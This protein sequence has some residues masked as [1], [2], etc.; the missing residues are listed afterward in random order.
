M[1]NDVIVY[2]NEN[3]I[4]YTVYIDIPLYVYLLIYI[5]IGYFGYI[6]N[7]YCM[8]LYNIYII[9]S[10]KVFKTIQSCYRI[11]NECIYLK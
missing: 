3:V 8:K 11:I 1:F 5:C 6:V 9:A 2:P 10:V 7:E 4:Y